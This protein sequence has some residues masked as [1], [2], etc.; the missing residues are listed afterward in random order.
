MYGIPNMKLEKQIVDRKISDYGGR[1]R[2]LRDQLRMSERMLRAEELLKEF[3]ARGLWPAALPIP[4]ISKR[5]EEMRRRDLLRGGLPDVHHKEP[6][7]F[8]RG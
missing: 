1:G 4:E 5:P 3:D 7:G 8:Q 6:S 2:Y